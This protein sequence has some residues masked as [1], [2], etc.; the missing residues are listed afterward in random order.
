MPFQADVQPHLLAQFGQ[1][2]LLNL[3][4]NYDPFCH[5]VVPNILFSPESIDDNFSM[6]PKFELAIFDQTQLQFQFFFTLTKD[7]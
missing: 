5:S 7:Q 4:Q 1:N 3:F 6:Y 2:V